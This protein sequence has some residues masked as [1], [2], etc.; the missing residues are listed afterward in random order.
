GTYLVKDCDFYEKQLTNK[1]VGIGVGPAIGPQPVPTGM[2]KVKPVPTGKPKVTPVPTGKPKVTPVPTGKPKATSVPNGLL[3]RDHQLEITKG[4]YPL[5]VGTG[6]GLFGL[7]VG[8]GVDTY[9]LPV[10]TGVDTCGLPL[11]T[12]VAFGLPVG[13]GVTLGLPVG[14][15]VTFGLPVG[16]GCGLAGGIFTLPIRRS[17]PIFDSISASF[18]DVD[19]LEIDAQEVESVGLCS[20]D[21]RLESL[22][23]MPFVL[24]SE[25]LSLSS[26]KTKSLG[27]YLGSQEVED[28]VS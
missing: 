8:T 27:T 17:V 10:G 7:P 25:D 19:T 4:E 20:E 21:L 13:T 1:T 6:K 9:G 12:D 5:A 18:T 28:F 11:G 3:V 14:T 16:T 2:P 26:H 23:A 22:E 15:G 24:T